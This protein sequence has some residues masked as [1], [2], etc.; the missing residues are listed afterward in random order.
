MMWLLRHMRIAESY[1][2][3][4]FFI[5]I[6]NYVAKSE[7][8]IKQKKKSCTALKLNSDLLVGLVFSACYLFIITVRPNCYSLGFFYLHLVL[9]QGPFMNV[10]LN[11]NQFSL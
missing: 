10:K 9:L 2:T 7:F 6:S 11:L 3:S 4:G 1:G 8:R 5:F